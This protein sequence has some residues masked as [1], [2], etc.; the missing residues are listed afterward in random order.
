MSS[1]ARSCWRDSGTA[2][3]RA[4]IRFVASSGSARDSCRCP[5]AHAEQSCPATITARPASHRGRWSR[6]VISRRRRK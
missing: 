3:A 4:K 6:S 2:R 1:V 5:T